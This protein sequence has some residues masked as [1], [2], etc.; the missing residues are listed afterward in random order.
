MPSNHWGYLS[1]FLRLLN[2]QRP[3][4]CDSLLG[5]STSV[6]RWIRHHCQTSPPRF[7]QQM[8]TL[9][10]IARHCHSSVF[11]R[12]S[13]LSMLFIFIL[14]LDPLF[15]E[16]N[17]RSY[18][19]AYGSIV[20]LKML[21]EESCA[22]LCFLTFAETDSSDRVLLD[23]PHS[24]NGQSLSINKYDTPDFIC[25]LS[26]FRFIEPREAERIQRWYSIY[27]NFSSLVGPLRIM[28]KTQLALI[29][30][31]LKG[32]I[33]V[34][35]KNL[36]KAQDD[37]EESEGKYQRLQKDVRDASDATEQLRSQI[38]QATQQIDQTKRNFQ[39]Q[40]EQCQRKNQALIDA[41][42]WSALSLQLEFV[43]S[44]LINQSRQMTSISLSLSPCSSV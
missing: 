30:H 6:S 17:L 28:N 41:M 32:Q 3:E 27:R 11:S 34:E 40:I 25:S 12:Y 13:S 43:F 31:D 23:L 35:E 8:R 39:E 37:L 38:E 29:R 14:L 15:T 42:K 9:D 10:G 36:S 1:L 16:E 22:G 44:L 5:E 7:D 21:E 24:L 19:G 18:F 33:S 2:V 20:D 26:Q 4:L